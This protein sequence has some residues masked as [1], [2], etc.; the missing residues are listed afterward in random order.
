MGVDGVLSE[1]Y[2]REA[3]AVVD[4]YFEI[5]VGVVYN[6]IFSWKYNISSEIQSCSFRYEFTKLD[7]HKCAK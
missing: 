6:K 5:F 7:F 1:I 2:C 4:G 3:F